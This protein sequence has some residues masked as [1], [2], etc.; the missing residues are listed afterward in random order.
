MFRD[1]FPK[2]LKDERCSNHHEQHH[3]IVLSV[4]TLANEPAASTRK[5]GGFGASAPSLEAGQ[6]EPL[7]VREHDSRIYGTLD[8]NRSLV[9]NKACNLRYR[10]AQFEAK[11]TRNASAF[12]FQ[13]K[14]RIDVFE[15]GN[16]DCYLRRRLPSSNRK[17]IAL[18]RSCALAFER[19]EGSSI[20]NMCIAA[21]FDKLAN[22]L[23][24]DGR[25]SAGGLAC[26]RELGSG[27]GSSLSGR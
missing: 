16:R 25:F 17:S 18:E 1:L 24:N 6:H 2:R 26:A 15:P 21:V 12:G 23:G 7:A 11:P 9:G 5:A 4:L 14:V 20:D 19:V 8:Q 3:C 13:L 10:G 27:S 22:D